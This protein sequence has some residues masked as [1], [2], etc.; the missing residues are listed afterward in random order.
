MW[1][2]WVRSEDCGCAGREGGVW[3][4]WEGSEECECAG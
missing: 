1:V 4:C 3:V 2:C